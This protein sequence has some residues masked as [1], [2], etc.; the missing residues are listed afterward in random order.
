[1]TRA[2]DRFATE[3]ERLAERAGALLARPGAW[4][5]AA[6]GGYVV[7]AAADRRRRPALRLDEATFAALVEA[8]GLRPRTGGGWTLRAPPPPEAA[9]PRRPPGHG[10]RRAGRGRNGRTRQP[11]APP[12]S[13]RA[14]WRGWRAG[15]TR[16]GRPGSLPSRS[17]RPSACAWT[18]SR[19]G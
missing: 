14:R 10:A 13:A 7:R 5:E 1:M 3:A 19:R 15:A 18:W 17:P 11:F 2:P 16:K 8:P 6:D 4:L 12:T 9:A